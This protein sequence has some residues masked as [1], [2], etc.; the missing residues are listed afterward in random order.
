MMNGRMDTIRSMG[1]VVSLMI[2]MLASQTPDW[3]NGNLLGFTAVPAAGG[4]IFSTTYDAGMADSFWDIHGDEEA[5]RTFIFLNSGLP[6]DPEFKIGR[7]FSEIKYGITKEFGLDMRLP[8][9]LFQDMEFNVEAD[10]DLNDMEGISGIGD[11]DV[12]LYYLIKIDADNSLLIQTGTRLATGSG[13]EEVETDAI[14]GQD[15]EFPTGTGCSA[16]YGAVSGDMN[17]EPVR[18]SYYAAY[19]SF[20]E[21]TLEYENEDIDT[22]PGTEFQIGSQIYV[23]AGNNTGFGLNLNFLSAEKYQ[24]HGDKIRNSNFDVF[25]IEPELGYRLAL[26]QYDV[27]LKGSLYDTRSGK[28]T[29]RTTGVRL[30]F[31]LLMN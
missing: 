26:G 30:G 2:G 7:L 9:T 25:T 3:V 4:F 10:V 28:N 22:K 6:T 15:L 20:L 14:S 31:D 29:Y 8:Y 16:F 19:R 21:T 18:I 1:I 11:L 13:P 5:F 17:M 23:P 27:I 24:I 12:G